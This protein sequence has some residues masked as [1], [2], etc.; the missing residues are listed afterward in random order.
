MNDVL[1][2][3]E[4]M[5]SIWTTE[6]VFF[7]GESY[8][9]RLIHDIHTARTLITLEVYI[10][11]DDVLGQ[12][13]ADALK[14]ASH[15]G[16]KIQIIVDGV[17]SSGFF[18]RLYTFFENE[19]IPV[20]VYNPLP[21][22]HPYYRK[23]S[24]SEKIHAFFIR[25]IRLNKRDHRK[26]I[27]IDENCMYSG[28]FNI[29]SDHINLKGRKAWKDLGIRVSGEQVKFAV[30]NFKLVWKL[31]DYYRYRKYLKHKKILSWKQSPIQL[32]H[33][34]VMKRFFRINF[35]N[36]MNLTHQRVWLMTP[37]FIPGRGFIRS[38]AR[39]AKRG[40]DVRLII[41]SKP[42]V[43]IFR[44]LQSFYFLFLIKSGVQI[45]EYNETVLHAKNYILDDWMTVG[46]TNLNHRSLMH[47]L[48]VDLVI[49]KEENSKALEK[50]FLTLTQG[51]EP[52][53]LAELKKK[54]IWDM[55]L[56]RLYFLFRYWL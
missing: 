52:L 21:F 18:R 31:V 32:N 40:V 28:S 54:S 46:S 29:T 11:N 6:E 30:L 48:E 49:Q 35:V 53:T 22:L 14:A 10:F 44:T 45:F 1:N 41:S 15:R 3:Q 7:D 26:I 43:K 9:D 27:T 17:G 34:L 39:A 12:R 23:I 51:T 2:R 5:N 8:F 56:S 33:T 47:D 36:K 42:D 20:K 37:Y 19:N 16:V 24:W 55:A 50:H 38:M 13:I 4:H 25:M